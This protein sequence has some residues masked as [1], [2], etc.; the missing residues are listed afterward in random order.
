MS[1]DRMAAY[2]AKQTRFDQLIA[3]TLPHNKEVIFD[4]LA[5]AGIDH[6]EV[7]F[8]GYGDSGAFEGIKAFSGDNEEAALPTHE[9]TLKRPIFDTGIIEEK[10]STPS[11]AIEEMVNDFLEATRSGWENNEGAFGT[12]RLTPANQSIK[13]EYNER[14]VDTTY[15]EHEF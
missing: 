5:A 7:E 14:F 6:V 13:L 1:D 3:E 15:H 10:I 9:I 8:D 4:V 12:F 2:E 11:D